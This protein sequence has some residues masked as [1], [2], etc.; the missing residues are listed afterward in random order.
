MIT[1]L[2]VLNAISI[3][4]TAYLK[5]EN[6]SPNDELIKLQD[7]LDHREQRN[8]NLCLLMQNT[9]IITNTET[10]KIQ[11]ILWL[12]LLIMS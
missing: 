4:T 8:G 10:P 5:I 1:E 6:A 3:N 12:Q 7:R 2:N 11:T 9:E